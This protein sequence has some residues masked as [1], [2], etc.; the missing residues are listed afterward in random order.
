MGGVRPSAGKAGPAG[1][2]LKPVLLLL[3]LSEAPVVLVVYLLLSAA[4][5]AVY[6]V[7]GA[8]R[9]LGGVPNNGLASLWRALA[10]ANRC[11]GGVMPV[12]VC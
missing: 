5:A 12:G 7:A 9:V 6:C 10:A 4:V 3:V 1:E 2:I 8:Y 11:V